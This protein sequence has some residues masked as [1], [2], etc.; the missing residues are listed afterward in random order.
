M[1]DNM[2]DEKLNQGKSYRQGI[3]SSLMCNIWWGLM[4]VYWQ[5][6]R[7]IGSWVIIFYRIVLVAAVCLIAAVA[8]YDKKTV[9]APLKDKKTVIRYVLAVIIMPYFMR[10]RIT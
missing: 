4:P 1:K 7:P 2:S 3:F 5:A 10:C 9:F 6:L 8:V